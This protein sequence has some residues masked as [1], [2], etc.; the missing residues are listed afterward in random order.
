M[1]I[2]YISYITCSLRFHLSVGESCVCWPSRVGCGWFS[3]C[4]DEEIGGTLTSEDDKGGGFIP[5]CDGEVDGGGFPSR[6]DGKDVG[7]FPSCGD[8]KGGVVFPS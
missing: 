6:Q 1:N 8:K 3:S 7:D 2:L 5:S 4:E